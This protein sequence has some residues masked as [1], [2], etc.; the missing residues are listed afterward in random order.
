MLQRMRRFS[1]FLHLISHDKTNLS[2]VFCNTRANVEHVVSNLH[3][4]KVNA[5]GIHGGMNQAKRQ[6]TMDDFYKEHNR[7]LVCTDVAARGL[8]IEGVTHVY[9]YDVPAKSDEYIHRVGRTARA[10]KDG[11]AITLVCSKDY[12]NFRRVL[13]D[14][15]L[16]IEQVDTPMFKKVFVQFFQARRQRFWGKRSREE[17]E[18]GMVLIV[19]GALEKY[20]RKIW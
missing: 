12:D 20:G 18:E 7:I 15:S 19:L 13:D 6:K 16:K 10:G 17:V 2:M 8:D 14:D 9:N 1:L 3:K 11:E 5:V 4:H